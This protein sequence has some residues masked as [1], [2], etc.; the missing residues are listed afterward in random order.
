MGGGQ[1]GDIG[2]IALRPTLQTIIIAQEGCERD[3]RRK[4]ETLGP[5]LNLFNGT[6]TNVLIK[7]TKAKLKLHFL[8][9]FVNTSKR[10]NTEIARE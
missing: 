2:H 9:I 10:L 5:G 1:C 3:I 7:I 4:L 8:N 6:C